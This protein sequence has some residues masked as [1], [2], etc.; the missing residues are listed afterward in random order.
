MK[1]SKTKYFIIATLAL[2]AVF[3]VGSRVVSLS[4]LRG[5][6]LKTGWDLRLRRNEILCAHQGVNSFRIWNHEQSLSGFVPISRPDYN[7]VEKKEG[8][9]LVHAYP[10]WH[11]TMFWFYGWLSE[12]ECVVLMAVVFGL[13]LSFIVR[14][15]I[16]ISKE[17]FAPYKLVSALSLIC[18]ANYATFCFFPLNYGILVLTMFLL[19]NLALKKNHN[20]LAGV[21][22]AIMMI[23]PQIGVLF[24]WPLFWQKR[25]LTIITGTIVCLVATFGTS[26]LVHDSVIDL[27]MQIPEIGRPYV[28]G[29]FKTKP[30]EYIFGDKAFLVAPIAFSFLV[31]IATWLMRKSRDFF[32]CCVPVVLAIPIWT[33]CFGYDRVILL[34]A[35]IVL[36]GRALTLRKFD[37]LTTLLILYCLTMVVMFSSEMAVGFDFFENT[38]DIKAYNIAKIAHFLLMFVMAGLFVYEKHKELRAAGGEACKAC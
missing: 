17:Y 6:T 31:G 26:L 24:F 29:S 21:A 25:Y 14:E 19:M 5:S 2:F 34:P 23:K 16:N 27:I 10:A 30:F 13:C 7:K 4:Q 3:Q 35:F 15:T 33:Y 8:D 32:T 36:I 12:E 22:W 38:D 1:A 9:V 20:I 11:T 28:K 37:L 18:I